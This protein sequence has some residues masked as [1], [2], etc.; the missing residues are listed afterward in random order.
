[1]SGITVTGGVAW[2]PACSASPTSIQNGHW[3]GG[4]GVTQLYGD[5]SRGSCG[6]SSSTAHEIGHNAGSQH[7]HCYSPADRP[8]L[9]TGD[10]GC[11]SGP[12]ENPGPGGGTIMSYCHLLAGLATSTSP[13]S[14]TRAAST[15]RCSP[16]SSRRPA[17]PR[18]RPSRT[19]RRRARSSTTSRRSTSSASPAAARGGNYCPASPVTRAADGGLPAEGQARIGLHAA[20]R[21]PGRSS[22]TCPAR[23]PFAP[24]DRGAREPRHHRRLRRRQLLPGQH[25]HAQ[26]DGA[27]SPED[28]VR[29]GPRAA[30][31][32]PASSRRADR[33][34]SVRALD[35]GARTASGSR[36]AARP[37]RCSYCPDEPEHAR[38]R[39]R[40]S[41]SKTFNLVW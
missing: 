19:C 5:L 33:R 25:G 29:L 12:V 2:Q 24:L 21:A 31:A 38:R 15:S 39:W 32:A 18:C 14:S 37:R 17:S 35:Q 23:S 27:V 22:P 13:S 1:M 20:G 7:T 28:A 36:A 11:Y 3:G 26:A 10:A 8:L 40:S 41:W 4:Y 30:D 16:R 6:T 34:T 9:A